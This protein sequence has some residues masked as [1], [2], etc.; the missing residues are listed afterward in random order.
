MLDTTGANS[1]TFDPGALPNNTVFTMAIYTNQAQPTLQGKIIAAGTFSQLVG[2][3]QQNRVAR[4]NMDGTIDTNFNVGFG[5]DQPVRAM[6]MQPDGRVILGGLF[7]NVN[8]APRAWLARLNTDGSLDPNYNAGAGLN[9][10]VYSLA[11]QADQRVVLG[12]TFT[13]VYGVPRVGL[14]RMTPLGTV[15]TTFN[16]GAGANGAVNAIVID[17]DGGFIIGGDFTTIDNTP[18]NH[19]A[20]LL[21]SGA[22]DTNFVVGAGFNGTVYALAITGGGRIL[23]G[24]GFTSYDGVSAPRLARLQTGGNLDSS[25]NAGLGADEFVSSIS[26]Q[27][28][29][30]VLV[31]G[32]FLAFNGQLRNR[33]VRLNSDGSLDPTINFGTGADK[34]VY[35]ALVQYYD[36]MIVVGGSF[37]S[38]N[39]QPRVA[40]A[41][42]LGGANSGAGIIEFGSSSYS[43][44][45]AGTNVLLTVLRVGGA[46]GPAAVRLGT[47]DVSARSG[48]DYLGTNVTLAFNNAETFKTLAVRVFDN[49]VVD[50]NRTFLA[51]LSSPTSAV[52]GTPASALV[53]ILDND[54]VVSFVQSQYTVAEGGGVARILVTR[55]GG[56]IDTTTVGYAT[57]PSGTAITN[58]DY[59][60]VSGT[61]TFNPGVV[62]QSFDVP[63]IDNAV[64]SPNQT[65]SLLLSNVTGSSTLGL[66]RATLTIINNDFGP[67]ILSLSTNSYVVSASAINVLINVVRTNG[68]TGPVGVGF[69]TSDGTATAGVDY[70]STNGVLNFA[71]GETNK[72]ILIS[73]IPN[74]LPIGDVV[75]QVTLTNATG[76]ATLSGGVIAVVRITDHVI[77][78]GSVDQAFNPGVGAN[79][80]VRTVALDSQGRFLVG[81]G[82]TNFNNLGRNGIVRL[83]SDGSLDLGFAPGVGANFL[84]NAVAADSL[85]RVLVGGVFTNVGGVSFNHMARL[86]TN[87]LPD[88][89]YSQPNRLNAAVTAFAFEPDGTIVVVGGFSQPASGVARLRPD[90]GVD[91][92]FDP[93]TGA[94]GPVHAVALATVGGSLRIVVG[95][96]FNSFDG[97]TRSRVAR[98]NQN[99]EVD[100]AFVPPTVAGTVY[101]VAIQPDGKVIIGGTFTNVGGVTRRGVARLTVDGAPDMTFDPGAGLDGTAYALAW[102]SDGRILVGGDFT[103]VNQTNRNRIA[104]LNSNGSL[105]LS[106]DTASGADGAVY[107][108]LVLPDSEVLIGGDFTHVNKVP[109]SGVALLNGSGPAGM[110]AWP[111]TLDSGGFHVWVNSTPGLH[112][113]LMASD[114]LV[115]WFKVDEATASA[116]M[117]ELTDVHAAGRPWRFYRVEWVI[118]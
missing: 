34:T 91:T 21:P 55:A 104:R 18:R 51:G 16:P 32:G 41:R 33:L 101:S 17:G 88:A 105:D 30:K 113:V 39:G 22:L 85:D 74:T 72:S 46:A 15:D 69:F 71:D 24:G 3:G 63:I 114:D 93:G 53:T 7:T 4:L 45:E 38:F 5:P 14:A 76:G 59:V 10:A 36:G 96:S 43:V 94:D 49:R 54:C 115:G 107:A 35:G 82:F 29:G 109:R 12:G 13:M 28:D 1:A 112:Y 62:V 78:L 9:G 37:T 79:R 68:F 40:L 50:G 99:G 81:G 67:G 73:I 11:L 58:L 106:F 26:L 75:F 6:V 108:I 77:G 61:L 84:V 31:G 70:V 92:S 8:Q 111:G 25:F 87:G 97:F 66:S 89:T 23:V 19:I 57:G 27:S 116:V 117:L 95:G 98:L 2:V 20:R 103:H 64:I 47:T 65:V 100:T 52:L 80:L 56:A 42:L 86:L 110:V 118:P 44:S 48:Q 60:P 102:Q 83:N 90:G